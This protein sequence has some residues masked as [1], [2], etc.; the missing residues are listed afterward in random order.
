MKNHKFS[1]NKSNFIFGIILLGYAIYA[2]IYIFK[3]SFIVDGERYFV[4]FDEAMI[5]MQYAKN[6]ASGYGL[7]W[8]QG[9]FVEGF[10]NPL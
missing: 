8:S 1:L 5:S 4:L 10:S 9:E 3:S 2:G 6:L 7:V